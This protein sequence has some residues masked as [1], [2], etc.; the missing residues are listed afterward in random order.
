ML[1]DAKQSVGT[2]PGRHFAE[3]IIVLC[4]RG[5]LPRFSLSY[6]DLEELITERGLMSIPLRFGAGWSLRSRAGS[7]GAA[8]VETDGHVLAG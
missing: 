5:Y 6:R 8:G 2:F 1:P 4:V 7:A 3:E